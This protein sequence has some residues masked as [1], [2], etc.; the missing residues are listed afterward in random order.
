MALNLN[1]SPTGTT[2]GN[3]III[4]DDFI[5]VIKNGTTVTKVSLKDVVWAADNVIS[6]T[7]DL[8]KNSVITIDGTCV[9][10]DN[11]SGF[12]MLAVV[13]KNSVLA[14]KDFE[15]DK[16]FY[17]RDSDPSVPVGQLNIISGTTTNRVTGVYKFYNGTPNVVP[18]NIV[19]GQ[20]DATLDI[21][22]AI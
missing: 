9:S 16:L 7:I 10:A 21:V 1:C 18:A 6:Y 13:A 3:R 22:F 14:E 20:Y 2:D 11:S 12:I 15:N 5:T 19:D 17:Q 8:P 4:R